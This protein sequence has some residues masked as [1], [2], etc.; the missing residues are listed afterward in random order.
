MGW[1]AP[2]TA[3]GIG[4]VFLSVAAL[5]CLPMSALTKVPEARD[6]QGAVG[7]PTTIL[8][9]MQNLK[10]AIS[11]G[12][13]LQE[14]FYLEKNFESYFGATVVDWR[15]KPALDF[16]SGY[17]PAFATSTSPRTIGGSKIEAIS[18]TF[19]YRAEPD[20]V[21]AV[22]S[23][24]LTESSEVDFES[25]ESLYG[26]DWQLALPELP[27]VHRKQAVATRP[28]GNSHIVY[29]GSDDRQSYEIEFR[30]YPNATLLTV[31]VALER[32]AHP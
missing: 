14:G 23:F 8:G 17:L 18:A 22:W 7:R 10:A 3:L 25:I 1:T 29:A 19:L 20:K 28:H 4:C 6:L 26:R 13:L 31:D 24:V 32:K 30:F 12:V 15:K 11:T 27:S 21:T 2:N 16:R 5:S 9:I